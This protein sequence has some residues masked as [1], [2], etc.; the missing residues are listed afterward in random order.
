MQLAPDV[1]IPQTVQYSAGVDHQLHKSTTVSL[2]YTG[3]RGHHLFRSRD[4]NAP[5]PPLYLARPDS[6]FGAIRQVES[7][8]R[9]NSDSMS[10][11]LRG[12]VTRFNGQMQ[13]T[14]SRVDNDTNGVAW[15]PANDYDL[16]G[17]W[18]R[19]D[20]DRRHRVSAVR[21]DERRQGD[22]SR[23]R[24]DAQF[25]RAVLATLGADVYNN[26][27]GRAWP[28]GVARN[29]LEGDG[30]ASLD[31]RA[32]REVKFGTGKEAPSMTFGVDAFN[33]LNRVNYSSYVGT[34][35]S[36]LFGQP[37]SA[38]APRQLQFSGR[39]KF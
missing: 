37:V 31:L 14:L 13:Y 17:E 27:R 30:Y 8:G 26:G 35:S 29:T 12:R 19:A 5:L 38:R 28:A 36:P 20:F 33:L 39:F 1:R 6:E 2:T 11:T 24:I 7:A 4:I 3:A 18:A 9:Q 34:L 25:R 16:S 32:S 15:F 23:C 21:P 10:V 22:R